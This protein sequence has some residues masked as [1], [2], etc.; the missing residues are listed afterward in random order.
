MPPKEA[1]VFVHGVGFGPAVYEPFVTACSDV[2]TPVILVEIPSA[3]QHLFPRFPP[4]PQRFAAL[5]E[6]ALDSLGIDRAV[7]AGH[8]LGSAFASYALQQDRLKAVDARRYGGGVL[9]DPIA[10]MLHHATTTREYVYTSLATLEDA[11]FDFVFKKELWT[12]IVV[13]KHLPPHEAS[14]FVEDAC[15]HTPMLVA[16][17]TDDTIVA[18]RFIADQFGSA[19]ARREKG[20]RMHKM[21]GIGHGEWLFDD[22]HGP[23][24]VQ[25]VRALREVAQR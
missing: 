2:Q 21:E 18:N 5:L 9:V 25:A 16:I 4:S 10:T 17:G 14:F 24:L 6:S 20:I 8:S 23:Q 1:L 12:G 13:S 22:I 3:S 19:D 7:I 11:L 15:A